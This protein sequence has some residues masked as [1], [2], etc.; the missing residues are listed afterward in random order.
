[1]SCRGQ[2]LK[3]GELELLLPD[4]FNSALVTP[5]LPVPIQPHPDLMFGMLFIAGAL[6]VKAK[7]QARL[8]LA[9]EL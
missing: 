1:M 5:A 7:L 9:P 6:A 2:D 4:L 8:P 3:G